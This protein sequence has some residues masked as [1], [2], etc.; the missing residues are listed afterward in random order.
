MITAGD[1]PLAFIAFPWPI[2]WGHLNSVS[3]TRFLSIFGR[4]GTSVSAGEEHDVEPSLSDEVLLAQVAEGDLEAL[5]VLYRR[6]AGI[7]H[8]IGRRILHDES[9][10]ED[11]VQD[12]FL[13]LQ[14]KCGV[15]NPTKGN[16]SSWIIQTVYYQALQRRVRLISSHD[17][18]TREIEGMIPASM[19]ERDHSAEIVFG[20]STWHGILKALTVDQWET[21]RMH[22]FE[23]YTLSEIAQKRGESVG[24]AR[25][26]FYRGLEALRKQVFSG[27]LSRAKNNGK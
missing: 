18:S 15:F 8:G 5:A 14:R 22:F 2:L 11:L 20:R 17:Y 9:E 24:N 25:H 19:V 26:H 13:Y 23:G 16:A 3:P 6:Y 4:V 7:I 1:S 10:A 21:L 27:D 12:V